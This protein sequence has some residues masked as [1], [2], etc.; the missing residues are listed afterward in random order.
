MTFGE[1]WFKQAWINHGIKR[2][3][4]KEAKTEVSE[5]ASRVRNPQIPSTKKESGEPPVSKETRHCNL[6]CSTCQAL[7][8]NPT[9]KQQK[10]N[11]KQSRM[12]GWDETQLQG[13]ISEA[14]ITFLMCSGLTLA[15]KEQ[16]QDLA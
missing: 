4:P 11:Q 6:P 13:E 3:T 7:E 1:H 8:S 14:T 2:K 5:G 10:T 9:I 16:S 12:N 15:G